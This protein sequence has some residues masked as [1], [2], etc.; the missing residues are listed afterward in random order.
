MSL[1]TGEA[2]EIEVLESGFVDHQ[3]GV[4]AQFVLGGLSVDCE[5]GFIRLNLVEDVWFEGYI[6]SAKETFSGRVGGGA[7]VTLYEQA[8]ENF[9]QFS[10]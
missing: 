4:K 10:V 6:I 3:S 7:T 1:G 2:F 5:I 9:F 8:G